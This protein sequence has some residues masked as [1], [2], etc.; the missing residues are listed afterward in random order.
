M[1]KL[2]FLLLFILISCS[3]NSETETEYDLKC[4]GVKNYMTRCENKEVVCYTSM[5]LAST[6]TPFCNFKNKE[7][8]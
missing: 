7:N 5:Y 2:V 6:I 3:N 4:I 8:K 1:K